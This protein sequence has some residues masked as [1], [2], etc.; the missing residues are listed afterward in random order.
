MDGLKVEI[1]KLIIWKKSDF[2]LAMLP[3]MNHRN[4]QPVELGNLY[5]FAYFTTADDQSDCR[6]E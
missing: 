6:S 4:E 1:S 3:A 5:N 2:P